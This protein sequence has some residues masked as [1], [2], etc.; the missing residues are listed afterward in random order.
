MRIINHTRLPDEYLKAIVQMLTKGIARHI[1]KVT[2]SYT[3]T[4]PFNGY[5]HHVSPQEIIVNIAK[6]ES[7]HYPYNMNTRRN[8][9][10]NFPVY[11][12]DSEEEMALGVLAHEIYHAKAFLHNWKSTEKRAEAFAFKVLDRMKR[13]E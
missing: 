13:G 10:F 7:G 4:V 12:V 11:E 1:G 5:C 2:F 3:R 8:V 9:H 6:D